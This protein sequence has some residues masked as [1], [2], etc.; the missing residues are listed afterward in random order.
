MKAEEFGS[1][2]FLRSAPPKPI[3]ESRNPDETM[4]QR[5]IKQTP[6][7]SSLAAYEDL[8]E[9]LQDAAL[10]V[11]FDSFEILE[12]NPA[13]ER[14]LGYDP[15]DL[16]GRILTTLV[17]PD[18]Q[19]AVAQQLRIARRR[20]YAREFD[21]RWIAQDGTQKMMEVHTNVLKLDD[22]RE[23]LQVLAK[24]VTRI[25]EAE[26]RLAELSITDEL[27]GLA[28]I[29]Y[30]RSQMEEEMQRHHRFGSPFSVIFLDVDHFK[31][32][33]DTHGHAAGDRVLKELARTLQL[34]SRKTDLPA[35]YGGEEFVILCR[36]TPLEGASTYAEK[37][38]RLIE[39]AE[40]P[41]GPV[42]ASFGV[43]GIPENAT[44]LDDV[45]KR[46]DEALY[47]SKNA[48]RNQV[49][50]SRKSGA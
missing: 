7:P 33:N 40:I 17:H 49:R 50:I 6:R 22:G 44:T 8:F 41:H 2:T 12:G 29:R 34:N 46:A 43:A 1:R 28:N 18:E 14:Q 13:C 4:T 25:R 16:P 36:G 11:E 19:D 3:S 5:A 10:L 15:D 47:E 9:R 45:M 30:F 21:S 27:T 23:V 42:T 38:R 32:F 39:A 26:R 35:R 20:H 31:S 24:D 48:G 37:L